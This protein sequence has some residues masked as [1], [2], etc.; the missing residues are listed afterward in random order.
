MVK[1]PFWLIRRKTPLSTHFLPS[2][3][4]FIMMMILI[5]FSWQNAIRN[6][7]QSKLDQVQVRAD[8]V[9]TSI[10]QRLETYANVLRAGAGLFNSSTEVNKD[11]WKVFAES[12]DIQNRY[13]ALI[14]LGYSKVVTAAEKDAFEKSI[15]SEGTKNFTISPSEPKRT[16]YA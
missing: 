10:T 16:I 11:E 9:E 2:F 5:G 6:V 7:Q 15:Q 4:V 8:F 13:P 14:G 1:K 3:L 12:L